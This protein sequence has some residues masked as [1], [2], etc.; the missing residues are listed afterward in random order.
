MT[1]DV[2]TFGNEG[3]PVVI[4]DDFHP[5]PT[6]L[7]NAAF[8][9][10]YSSLTPGFPGLRAPFDPNYMGSAMPLLQ[11]ILVDVFGLTKGVVLS[12]CCASIVTL[13]PEEL[14]PSQSIPHIDGSDPN[15]IAL[16]HY[17]DMPEKGGTGFY[18]HKETGFEA[19]TPQREP[20]YRDAL[21][22]MY[23][24]GSFSTGAY[25]TDT[26]NTF[27]KIGCVEGC[28]NRMAIYRGN[29][30]H[31]GDINPENDFSEDP[32]KARLSINTFLIG[33]S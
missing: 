12:K 4:I 31:S 21:R 24:R 16:L 30:L 33:R 29:N 11:K 9:L 25:V 5:D 17:I 26:N 19:I 7:R 3:N 28:Y 15:Q 27:E 10:Q 6:A 23:E 20:R 1:Y 14:R 22:P 13:K 8:E 2:L 32:R 18:R